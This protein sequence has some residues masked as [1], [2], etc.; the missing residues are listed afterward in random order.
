MD[1]TRERIESAERARRRLADER[2]V[3]RRAHRLGLERKRGGDLVCRLRRRYERR[4]GET[5]I[6]VIGVV[7]ERWID[8]DESCKFP[9]RR[10]R[11]EGSRQAALRR[12][13]RVAR[14]GKVGSGGSADHDRSSSD[15]GHS[16]RDQFVVLAGGIDVDPEGRA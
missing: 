16:G 15:G 11:S 5:E 8:E 10:E 14:R 13:E 4:D 3:K 7:A 6:D 2:V 1:L 9:V 12:Q